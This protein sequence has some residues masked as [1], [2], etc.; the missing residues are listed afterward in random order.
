[1]I[2]QELASLIDKHAIGFGVQPT[3]I[4]T[5]HF[6]KRVEP[7]GPLYG[8]QKLA[9]CIVAGGHKKISVADEVIHYG[10][11]DY[12]IS[13]VNIPITGFIEAA[14]PDAPFLA[15]MIALTPKQILTV[16]QESNLS[17]TTKNID[18]T[19]SMYVDQL[20]GPLED[21]AT[22]LVRLLETPVDIPIMAP[23][24]IKEIIYRVLQGKQGHVLAAIALEGSST[25]KVSAAIKHMMAHYRSPIKVDELAQVVNMSASSFHRHFKEVTAMSPLQ[26]QKQLRLQKARELLLDS[27]QITE[28]AYQVGYESSSQFSREY[29]RMFGLSP[30]ED[31]K[32]F[33]AGLM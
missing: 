11:G 24:I 3:A 10:P 13:T 16:M 4:P 6:S 7:A 5:L 26:F 20:T 30:R 8:I 19:R 1:M 21:A 29:S 27:S 2:M 9:F 12:F 14:T 15:L 33:K 25:N 22:R 31:V 18:V 32:Q 23:M 28:V 17:Q